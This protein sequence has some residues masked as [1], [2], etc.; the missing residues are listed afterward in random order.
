MNGAFF[1]L[2]LGAG[3]KGRG[4]TAHAKN[5]IAVALQ[6]RALLPLLRVCTRLQQAASFRAAAQPALL[7]AT[8]SPGTPRDPPSLLP[9]LA[10]MSNLAEQPSGTM[11]EDP[12]VSELNLNDGG[13][14]G[15]TPE[16][17]EA[18]KLAKAAAKA[19]KEAEKAAKA[20][21]RTC[22]TSC[23]AMSQPPTAGS[24]GRSAPAG[25]DARC[26]AGRD[27]RGRPRGSSQGHVR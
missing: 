17:R 9:F 15:R 20:S 7:L 19:A 25:S 14:G 1:R 18:K 13:E 23:I 10:S 16:E 24:A 6:A 4:R 21:V 22:W 26:E 5:T 8:S 11:S 27:D 2:G 12:S 3:G